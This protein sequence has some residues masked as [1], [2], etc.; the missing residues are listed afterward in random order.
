MGAT[1][2]QCLI[3]DDPQV[4]GCPYLDWVSRDN[5]NNVSYD[6]NLAMKVS[7]NHA[8]GYW[9]YDWYVNVDVNGQNIRNDVHV[10]EY[11][12]WRRILRGWVY[13]YSTFNGKYRGSVKVNQWDTTI[14]F[15]AT[16]HDS[17]GHWGWNTYWNV[18]IPA[19]TATSRVR[20]RVSNVTNKSAH[21]HGEVDSRGSCGIIARW[22]LEYGINVY[23]EHVLDVDGK[24][25][26]SMDWD[27]SGLRSD[28][29]YQ[30]HIATTSSNGAIAWTG[31]TFR[32]AEDEVVKIIEPN[33]TWDGRIY[34]I[35][36]DGSV[37]K[38]KEMKTIS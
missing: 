1:W 24:D 31:G 2:W 4:W 25:V 12:P 26:L 28:T 27:I 7:D 32:T 5:Y 6:F 9:D 19:A 13:W 30:Y 17:V 21:L 14:R 29:T 16:F 36:S 3:A 35:E 8:M 33:K 18:G 20:T 38:V 15:R 37:R 23:N 11:T 34:V 10:K 22:R